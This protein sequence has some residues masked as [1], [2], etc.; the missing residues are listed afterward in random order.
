[1]HLAVACELEKAL[2]IKDRNRFRI[3]HILPDAVISAD[4]RKKNTHFSDLFDNGR[5]KHFDFYKFFALYEREILSDELYLGY[6]FH[7]IED[8][9]FRGILYY[10][11]GLISKRGDPDFLKELYRDYH[12]LNG[13]L[14]ENYGLV[15]DITEP[16]NYKSEGINEIFS[17]EVEDFIADMRNDFNEN[18]NEAPKHLSIKRTEEF[19]KQCAEAC[20]SEYYAITDGSHAIGAYDYSWETRNK[21]VN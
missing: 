8:G 5:R 4:K 3:G 14:V 19:I 13:R 17:F 11:I 15:F 16:E 1:M 21:N 10:D 6:Y 7:L 20:I 18:T 12:I 9:I 2:P